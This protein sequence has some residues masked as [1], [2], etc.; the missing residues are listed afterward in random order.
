MSANLRT[1]LGRIQGLGSAKSGTTHFLH[2][3]MTAAALLPLSFWF[4]IA[5]LAQVGADHAS[6]AVFFGN[7]V[8]AVLMFLFLGCALYHMSLGLQIVIEDYVHQEGAKLALLILVRLS[9]F[10]IGATAGLALARL[11]LAGH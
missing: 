9:A 7:P 5:A 4:A 2:Q 3:R 6:V 10:A 1:P 11:A 8:N